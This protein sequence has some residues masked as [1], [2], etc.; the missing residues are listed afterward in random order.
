[1][2]QTDIDNLKI[3]FLERS[4][5]VAKNQAAYRGQGWTITKE[6]YIEMWSK[7]DQFLHRGRSSDSLNLVRIDMDGDWDYDN[8]YII[9]RKEMLKEEARHKKGR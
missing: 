3:K 9:T 5:L 8:V 1:M 4:Y 6:E 7:D 2:K